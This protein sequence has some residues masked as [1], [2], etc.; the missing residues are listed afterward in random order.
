MLSVCGQM[1]FYLSDPV[2]SS[3]SL[4]SLHNQTTCSPN[5][6]HSKSLQSDPFISLKQARILS[7]ST[8]SVEGFHSSFNSPTVDGGTVEW[9]YKSCGIINPTNI[10]TYFHRT[11]YTVAA[12]ASLQ[13]SQ[14]CHFCRSCYR[15][16][17]SGGLLQTS[18]RAV[19]FV[20]TN[21]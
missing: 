4:Q 1:S 14:T 7:F 18:A 15:L 6:L 8:A 3:Y 10:A 12:R 16:F 19:T 13:L 9:T 2:S 17:P 11:D 20:S 21:H 5:S